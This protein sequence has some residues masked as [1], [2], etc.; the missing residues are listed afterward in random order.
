MHW[1]V[2]HR[3]QATIGIDTLAT[4]RKDWRKWQCGPA[5]GVTINRIKTDY[6]VP[7]SST[8]DKATKTAK[9]V[10]CCAIA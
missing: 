8:N 5:I 7:N 3:A 9:N 10:P 4:M 1:L 6:A 2:D